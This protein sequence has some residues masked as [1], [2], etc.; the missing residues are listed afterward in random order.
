MTNIEDINLYKNILYPN[1]TYF[2]DLNFDELVVNKSIEI[3]NSET[4]DIIKKYLLLE[5]EIGIIR[6]FINYSNTKFFIIKSRI[7]TTKYFKNAEYRPAIRAYEVPEFIPELSPSSTILYFLNSNKIN[8]DILK[9]YLS[10]L[11]ELRN[12]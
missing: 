3:T 4:I 8:L 11:I 6:I 2:T 5:N 7:I 12:K 1:Q 9:N 10:D